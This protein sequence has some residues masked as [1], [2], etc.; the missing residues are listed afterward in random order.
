MRKELLLCEK[1]HS[2]VKIEKYWKKIKQN[3]SYKYDLC[4]FHAKITTQIFFLVSVDIKTRM[5]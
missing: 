2:Y 1:K 3:M 4:F 5:R